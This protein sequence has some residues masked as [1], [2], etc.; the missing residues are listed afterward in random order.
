MPCKLAAKL[1]LII[2]AMIPLRINLS[3]GVSMYSRALA[4]TSER[5]SFTQLFTVVVS[6]RHLPYSPVC[7]QAALH[8]DHHLYFQQCVPS[9]KCIF[10]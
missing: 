2:K 7:I 6:L 5:V 8:H 4:Y 9:H 3:L 10:E 1:A